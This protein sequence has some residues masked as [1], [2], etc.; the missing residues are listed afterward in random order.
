MFNFRGAAKLNNHQDPEQLTEVELVLRSSKTK[1]HPRPRGS[2]F[3][4]NS[5]EHQGLISVVNEIKNPIKKLRSSS[6]NTIHTIID[7]LK[8]WKI[9]VLSW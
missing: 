6:F 9:A 1:F 8:D 5:A 2:G 4:H 3:N 7:S